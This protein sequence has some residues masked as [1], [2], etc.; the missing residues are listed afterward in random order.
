[1]L[2]PILQQILST[3]STLQAQ[4]FNM[5]TTTEKVKALRESLKKVRDQKSNFD[6]I[7][8]Q[9]IKICKDVGVNLT[10]Q[11]KHK[12]SILIDHVPETQAFLHEKTYIYI[13]AYLPMIGCMLTEID[14]RFNQDTEGS[15]K[16]NLLANFLA[17]QQINPI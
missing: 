5:L 3:S 9:A 15:L 10:P 2:S 1:M 14:C 7:F 11:R 8:D 4:N 12:V 13:N 17:L 6:S 16:S